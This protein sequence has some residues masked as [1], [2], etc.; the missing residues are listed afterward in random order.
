[1]DCH[2]YFSDIDGPL[3]LATGVTSARDMANDT[4]TFLKR[5][6]R[7]ENGAELGPRVLKATKTALTP[8]ATT[9]FCRMTASVRRECRTSHGSRDE[10]SAM[11]ATSAVSM[12]ASLLTAPIAM[13]RLARAAAGG[14]PG[15][16]DAGQWFPRPVG[17]GKGL[18]G[19]GGC[20]R[21]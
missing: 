16:A 20:A 21:G 13:P 4:D 6:A 2:Q 8:S 15:R 18:E 11:S 14:K 12:A 9:R 17:S 3:D 10:P 5:V 19:P 1:M 7:F